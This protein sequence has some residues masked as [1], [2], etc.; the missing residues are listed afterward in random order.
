MRP[1]LLILALILA[2]TATYLVYFT[3]VAGMKEVKVEGI[4]S[5]KADEVQR[6][7]GLE[8]GTPLAT[9]D[10]DDV[11]ANVRKLSK[12]DSVTVERSWPSTLVVH[13]VERKPLL[14]VNSPDGPVLVD[15]TGLAYTKV[16]AVPKGIPEL[17]VRS[18]APTDPATKAAISVLGTVP[19]GVRAQVVKLS[20]ETPGDVQ[21]VLGS[22]VTIVWGSTDDSDRKSKIL[23]ALLSRPG[24][25]YNVSAPGLPTVA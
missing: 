5:L 24:K 1:F 6:S 21:L 22:G 19:A 2:T 15:H 4:S 9:V 7:L 20:A 3:P 16:S 23:G 17:V 11:A 13:V 18:V 12:V 14:V 25:I 10:L 8:E